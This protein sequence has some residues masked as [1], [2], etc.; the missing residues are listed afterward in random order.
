VP[1]SIT[2]SATGPNGQPLFA[3]QAGMVLRLAGGTL[4]PLS[5]GALPPLN[6][7]LPLDGARLLALTVQGVQRV[8]LRTPDEARKG[9]SQ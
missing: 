9:Q 2:A 1:V 6:F 3:N 8:D 5:A 4:Q 7:L